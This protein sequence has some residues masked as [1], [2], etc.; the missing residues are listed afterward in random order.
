[1]KRCSS[2]N[3]EMPEH[4]KTYSD[5]E[6]TVCESCVIEEGLDNI[7]RDLKDNKIDD[8]SGDTIIK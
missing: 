7:F 1:M 5:Y 8:L 3:N 6:F 2:G 4:E